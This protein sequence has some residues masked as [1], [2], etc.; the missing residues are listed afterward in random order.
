MP[1]TPDRYVLVAVLN[2][3]AESGAEALTLV[4]SL[5]QSAQE[6]LRDQGLPRDS[7]RTQNLMLQDWFDQ[8]Q[9]RVTARVASHE[10]EISVS[11]VETLSSVIATLGSVVGDNLQLRGLRPT[12]SDSDPLYHEAQKLAVAQARSKAEVLAAATGITLGPVVSIQEVGNV[13]GLVRQPMAASGFG[14]GRALQ[15]QV[16][17]EPAT[18][19]VSAFVTISYAIG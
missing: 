17:L 5:V 19:T 7:L 16:P 1:A 3:M 12:V 2:A 15:P 11:D 6:S 9:Q 18:L 14:G 13:G 4:A 8:G 10:V